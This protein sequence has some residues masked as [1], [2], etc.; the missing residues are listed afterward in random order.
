MRYVVLNPVRAGMVS[1][2]DQWPWSNFLA[3]AGIVPAPP[4]LEVRWTLAQ[5]PP[6]SLSRQRYREFVSAGIGQQSPM[7]NVTGQIYL[8]GDAFRKRVQARID[9]MAPSLEHPEVQRRPVRPTIDAVLAVSSRHFKVD[10]AALTKHSHSRV[11]LAAALLARTDVG[12]KLKDFCDPLGVKPW[13]ACNLAKRA[14]RLF[15]IDPGFRRDIRTIRRILAKT[16]QSQ[17]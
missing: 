13:A 11:R 6:P 2:V 3:T 4:W 9:S 12:L 5:F 8:G 15:E 7:V 10:V 14:Q 16:T 1:R 17:T